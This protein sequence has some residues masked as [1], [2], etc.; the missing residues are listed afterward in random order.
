L[1]F[2]GVGKKVGA[3][4]SWTENEDIDKGLVDGANA[5]DGFCPIDTF[6]VSADGRVTGLNVDTGGGE[7]SMTS[8]L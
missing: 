5:D 8:G 1:D 4:T 7:G 3:L 6:L 2:F